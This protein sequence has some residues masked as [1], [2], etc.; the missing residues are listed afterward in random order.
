MGVAMERVMR[1]VNAACVVLN[2]LTSRNMPKQV[3]MD[4]VIEKI[5]SLTRYQLQYTIFP[6]YDPV[7]RSTAKH[8]KGNFG[9]A[10]QIAQTGNGTILELF[11]DGFVGGSSM[12]KKRACAR[13]VKEKSIVQL[14]RRLCD[15]VTA[16]SE[17]CELQLFTDT[18]I[19]QLSTL[20]VSP[21]FVENVSELQLACL[22]LVT[23]VS[24]IKFSRKKQTN[25]QTN[26]CF[27]IA[28]FFKIREASTF[29]FRRY[30][31]VNSPLAK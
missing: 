3:Y 1:S 20:G 27:Q 5:V 21:F 18:T 12:K 8:K 25:K 14:Y 28:D 23:V 2:I 13:E 19:L 31:G 22:K 24:T 11:A 26:L 29:A 7:Y 17:L 4:D 30:S 10:L 16:L 6:S 15:S 9:G